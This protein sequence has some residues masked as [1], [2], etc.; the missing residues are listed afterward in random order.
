MPA[1][2]IFAL[3]F[4][5]VVTTLLV[6]AAYWVMKSKEKYPLLYN[7]R[8]VVAAFLWLIFNSGDL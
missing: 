3:I 5:V 4:T 1:Q 2:L 6:C 7:N 8:R